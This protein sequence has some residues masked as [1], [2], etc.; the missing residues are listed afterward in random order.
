MKAVTRYYFDHNATTPV[1]P[2][3]FHAMAP[4]MTTYPA[5]CLTHTLSLTRR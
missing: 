4:L 3:V 1:S 2:E 5:E